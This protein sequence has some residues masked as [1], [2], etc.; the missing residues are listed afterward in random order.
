MLKQ[1]VDPSLKVFWVVFV[2]DI[3]QV[4]PRECASPDFLPAVQS[5]PS[6]HLIYKYTPR[7]YIYSLGVRKRARDD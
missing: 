4:I 3:Y 5:L 2:K 1:S 6:R 7:L